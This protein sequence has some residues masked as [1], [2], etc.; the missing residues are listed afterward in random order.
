MVLLRIKFS[1]DLFVLIL[2]QRV[3]AQNHNDV[4]YFIVL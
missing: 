3:F 4:N 1:I 2:C